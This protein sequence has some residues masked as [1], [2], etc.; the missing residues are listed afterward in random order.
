[1]TFE[2][3]IV[4][5]LEDIKAVI[6]ECKCGARISVPTDKLQGIPE[7]CTICKEIWWL[8][9]GA[10]PFQTTTSGAAGA[11]IDALRIMRT[12]MREKPGSFKILFEFEEEN[13]AKET[14]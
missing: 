7:T 13:P 2:R 12:L 11:L 6:L 8:H 4:A 5:G 14:E 10:S 1:M 3:K 9:G